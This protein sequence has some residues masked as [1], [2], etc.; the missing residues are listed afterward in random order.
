MESFVVESGGEQNLNLESGRQS[1]RNEEEKLNEEE[2]ENEDQ[3][4]SGGGERNTVLRT[5][6]NDFLAF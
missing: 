5:K 4:W 3:G 2:E 6:R 1:E